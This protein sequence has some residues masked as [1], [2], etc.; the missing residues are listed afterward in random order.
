MNAYFTIVCSRATTIKPSHAFRL[1]ERFDRIGQIFEVV[2]IG[3][4]KAKTITIARRSEDAFG[5]VN[6]IDH[7]SFPARDVGRQYLKPTDG[8]V[9]L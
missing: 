2:R 5:K 8:K 9:A 1:G 7:T 3:R 4:D 6:H